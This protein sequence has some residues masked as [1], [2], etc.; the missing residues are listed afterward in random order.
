MTSTVSF[1]QQILDDYHQPQNDGPYSM[2]NWTFCSCGAMELRRS[3]DGY[4]SMA[5]VEY[6]C[7]TAEKIRELITMLL[8]GDAS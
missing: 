2:I 7:G 3:T 8:K 4:S 5:P 1:L 6:P